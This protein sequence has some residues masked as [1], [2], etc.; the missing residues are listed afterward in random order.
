MLFRSH[1]RVGRK[2]TLAAGTT[3]LH[4]EEWVENLLPFDRPVNWVQ[5][6][7]FGP[8]FVEP[9]KSFLDVSAVRGQ[10]DSGG[11]PADS[12][13]AGSLVEWPHGVADT[14]ERVSLSPFQ[15]KA[16][17]G[18]YFAVLLDRRRP[19]SFF[20]M[21]ND[22]FPVLIGYLFPTS[23]HPWLGDFQEN[24]RIESKPWDGQVV[25]RGIEFGSTPFPEGLRRSVERGTMYGVPTYRWIAAGQRLETSFDIFLAEIPPRFSGVADVTADSGSIVI[26]ERGSDRKISVPGGPVLK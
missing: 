8:P 16:H 23:D 24:Q 4:V 13:R 15:P 5:H 26:H 19:Q 22:N 25:T 1:Y 18:T 3:L 20:T 2:V 9:G 17:S 10:V 7:T 6:A 11:S 21:Y 12:L 14:G